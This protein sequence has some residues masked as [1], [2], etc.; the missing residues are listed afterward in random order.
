M[1]KICI[2]RDEIAVCLHTALRKY[3]DC[4]ASGLLWNMFHELND[5][6]LEE[7]YNNAHMKLNTLELKNNKYEEQ[8]VAALNFKNY[9]MK[10]MK[11][12][13]YCLYAGFNKFTD[14]DW[15]SYIS[16][17]FCIK[18]YLIKIK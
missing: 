12:Y 3:C 7:F 15:F 8:K 1:I 6:I 10:D 13:S 2:P 17:I 16:M 4:E 18:T 5:K 9:M 11:K 14:G